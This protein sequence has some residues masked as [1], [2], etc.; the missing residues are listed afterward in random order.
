[1]LFIFSDLNG[2]ILAFEHHR[3]D[4]AIPAIERLKS[5]KIPLILTTGQ[6]YDETIHFLKEINLIEPVIFEN[7][8][9]ILIPK[10]HKL[11]SSIF[12]SNT[13]LFFELDDYIIIQKGHSKQKIDNA[14]KAIEKELREQDFYRKL[15]L[16]GFRELEL[17]ELR[18]LLNEAS[19]SKLKAAKNRLFSESFEVFTDDDYC[20]GSLNI[21]E[22]SF[23]MPGESELLQPSLKMLNKI[24]SK[25][26]CQVLKGGLSY[27]LL[28]NNCSK[29]STIKWFLSK[30]RRAYPE[31]K[32]ASVGIGDGQNDVSMLLSV[33]KAIVIPSK[34]S[35]RIQDEIKTNEWFQSAFPAPEG[36]ANSINSILDKTLYPDLP[37]TLGDKQHI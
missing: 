32:I 36:W 37:I 20:E 6:T 5:H 15:R 10:E 1:M 27:H 23:A 3:Y 25:Y 4:A 29:G 34:I 9:G 11:Y 33:D 26:D 18:K 21:K 35:Y 31:Q 28:S 16:V 24:A 7:G 13:I 17:Y 30:M 8:S 19:N 12:L 14:L 22:V 2:T